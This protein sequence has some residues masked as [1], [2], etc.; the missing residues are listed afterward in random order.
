[1]LR[2]RRGRFATADTVAAERFD[3]YARAAAFDGY[4]EA[5]ARERCRR[6]GRGK[7][8]KGT[9]RRRTP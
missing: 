7:K 1:M 4:A 6:P 9:R 8:G 5:A 3:E 2:D